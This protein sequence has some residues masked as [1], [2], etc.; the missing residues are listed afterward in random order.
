MPGATSTEVVSVVAKRWK[1]TPKEERAVYHARWHKAN[2]ELK[3]ALVDG[4]VAIQ[5]SSQRRTQK[6]QQPLQ[7]KK[8]PGVKPQIFKSQW[9]QCDTCTKW[10][11]L[12]PKTDGL[13]LAVESF[14][15][16]LNVWDPARQTCDVPEED[17]DDQAE[18]TV[19][20]KV[21]KRLVE[22]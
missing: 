5:E 2:E 15:C 21:V 1:E 3:K 7:K 20:Y 10:R 6:L 13:D 12:P 4:I 8:K 14:T 17:W 22:Y 19:D 18:T 11:R 9:A 16:S